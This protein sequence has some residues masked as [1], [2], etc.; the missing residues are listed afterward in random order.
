MQGQVFGELRQAGSYGGKIA[1]RLNFGIVGVVG[2]RIR[3]EIQIRIETS[4][5][6]D[7]GT[8]LWRGIVLSAV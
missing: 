4:F 2:I 1:V 7:F 3:I 8:Y 6:K 5:G